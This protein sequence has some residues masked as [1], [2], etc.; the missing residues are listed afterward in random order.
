MRI[1]FNGI[2]TGHLK[3]SWL[4]KIYQ[5]FWILIEII[6]KYLFLGKTY[7]VFCPAVCVPPPKLPPPPAMSSRV[8]SLSRASPPGLAR[9]NW[10][11]VG[12][13]VEKLHSKLIINKIKVNKFFIIYFFYNLI[14]IWFSLFQ[15]FFSFEFPTPHLILLNIRQKLF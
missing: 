14:N 9:K 15:I 2:L 8:S 13:N 4:H 12:E 5:N 7:P 1:L 6:V 3:E 10:R 11:N